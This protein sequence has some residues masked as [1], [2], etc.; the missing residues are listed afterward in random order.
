MV[1]GLSRITFI[2][3]DLDGMEAVLAGVLGARKAY[4]GGDE[5]FLL[6][7]VDGEGSSIYFQDHDNHLFERHSG[8]LS[9]GLRRYARGP[10]PKHGP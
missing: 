10:T 1:T 9:E 6:S 4:D 3:R 7:P 5:T 8:T 2:V